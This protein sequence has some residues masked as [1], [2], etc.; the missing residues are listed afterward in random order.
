MLRML[1]HKISAILFESEIKIIDLCGEMVA[2]RFG[3]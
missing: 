1:R 2:P 3:E